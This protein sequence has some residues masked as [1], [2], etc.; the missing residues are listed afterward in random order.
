M[1][2]CT[3]GCTQGAD[4]PARVCPLHTGHSDASSAGQAEGEWLDD[5]S[6]RIMQGMALAG[7]V[8]SVVMYASLWF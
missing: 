2:C 7:F 6:L 5:T 8:V 1:S 4:C 3:Y